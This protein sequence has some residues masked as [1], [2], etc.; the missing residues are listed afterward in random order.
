MSSSLP[1]AVPAF[2]SIATA[3][4]PSG[5]LVKEGSVLGPYD[6]P[7]ALLI[8]GVHFLMDQPAVLGPDYRHEEHYNIQC[9]L[10]A[11]Q[12]TD[13]QAS[14][15]GT[16]YGLYADISI[17]VANA[18]TLNGTVRVALTRQLDYAMGYDPKGL[19]VGTCT[20]EVVCEARVTSES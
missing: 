12:G 16:A 19:A 9:T 7:Q 11:M 13:D 17:A 3:A 4:L 8:T 14:L 6:P 15:L 2:A 5:F 18:P 20:F 1:N 10:V